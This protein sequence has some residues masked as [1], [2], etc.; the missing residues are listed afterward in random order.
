MPFIP[1]RLPQKHTRSQRRQQRRTTKP[2]QLQVETL[3]SRCCLAA[4]GL[5]PSTVNLNQADIALLADVARGT[6]GVDGTGIRV[7]IIS[8]SFNA[9]GGYA[10]DV[11][12]GVLPDDVTVVHEGVPHSGGGTFALNDEGR[13]MAQIVHA[14]APGADIFFSA[15]TSVV[16]DPQQDF[17][18]GQPLPS[19]WAKIEQIQ[20]DF[21]DRIRELA[22]DY[23]CQIIVDDMFVIEPF[24]QDG[25]ISQA[26][27]EVTALGV[28]YFTAANNDSNYGYQAAYQ[29]VAFDTLDATVPDATRQLLTGKTL[30]NFATAEDPVAFQRI[31]LHVPN[32]DATV[33]NLQWAQPWGE[34]ASDVKLIFFDADFNAI[35]TGI[36]NP[37]GTWP[38]AQLPAL[39]ALRAAQNDF[40]VA[41]V[42][43]AGTSPDYLKW[44]LITNGPASI[45]VSP[46]TGFQTGTSYGHTNSTH[47]A[48]VGAANYWSTPAYRESPRLS[49]FSSWGGIPVFFDAAGERLAEPEYRPQPR[50]VAPQNGDTSFFEYKFF[51]PQN[52]NDPDRT[53][54]NN[55][56]GTSAAAPN[57]AAVA[58]LMKQLRPELTPDD[59]FAALAATATPF[60]VPG[61]EPEGTTNVAIGAG[62]INARDALAA[63]ADISISGV[64]FE[65]LDRDGLR[66]TAE[67]GVAG[68]EVFLDGNGNGRRDATPAAGSG[69][70]FVGWTTDTPVVLPPAPLAHAGAVGG[71]RRGHGRRGDRCRRCLRADAW[72]RRAAG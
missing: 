52:N 48:S 13:A 61:Y 27:S 35:T 29:P 38:A 22:I 67:V 34:N 56:S 40:Y 46:A 59:I 69:Q 31:T 24:F 19:V 71:D 70:A 41:I 3:E 23:G 6:Y 25:P 30:H 58:A 10:Y 68:M 37:T 18:D 47:G 57:T 21:A 17:V 4:T 60:A 28:T 44:I 49:D 51:E 12:R 65:D 32:P 16:V 36:E 54:L 42:H 72:C 14:V 50:F 8:D 20:I 64:V 55:F 11:S 9:L 39:S 5:G 15:N 26:I 62:L 43:E 33:F 66:D 7:G 63:V 53:Q 2:A 1:L 45:S